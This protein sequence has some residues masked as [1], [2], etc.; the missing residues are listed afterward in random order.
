MNIFPEISLSLYNA[1][2]LSVI[3]IVISTGLL[4]LFPKH[5]ISKFVKTPRIKYITEANYIFYYGFLIFS[6]FIPMKLESVSFYAGT[7]LLIV[8]LLLYTTATFYF[9]I[10]EYDQPVTERIYKLSRH[11]VYVSFFIISIGISI[12]GASIILSIIAVLHFIT[13]YFI[14]KKEEQQCIE[15]YGESYLNYMKK[16]RMF[17]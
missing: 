2:V 17:L 11:P 15:M 7:G 16:V 13:S 14:A 4:L 6:I 5:N 8:G 9:A 1:W 10:S 3:Y 12:A